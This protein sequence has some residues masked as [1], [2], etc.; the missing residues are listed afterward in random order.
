[1]SKESARRIKVVLCWGW[2]SKG[3]LSL[4]VKPSLFPKEYI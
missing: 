1:M 4:C 3:T 2:R